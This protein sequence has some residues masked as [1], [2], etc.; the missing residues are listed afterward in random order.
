[1][2]VVVLVVMVVVVV[3]VWS[4]NLQAGL[5]FVHIGSEH[6]VL[7]TKLVPWTDI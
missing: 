1:M 4:I 6:S 3:R 5:S 2:L 7:Y